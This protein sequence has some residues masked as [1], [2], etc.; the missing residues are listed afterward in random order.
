[1][2]SFA[3]RLPKRFVIPRS[4]SAR[5]APEPAGVEASGAFEPGSPV[6]T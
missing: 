5:S 3:T 1:M 2:R 6:T 4:S